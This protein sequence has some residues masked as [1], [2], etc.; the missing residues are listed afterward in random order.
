M[1]PAASRVG[2]TPSIRPVDTAAFAVGAMSGPD[3][4]LEKEL[5]DQLQERLATLETIEVALADEHDSEL[6]EVHL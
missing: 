3:D 2:Y 4:D 6:L 1:P 5:H